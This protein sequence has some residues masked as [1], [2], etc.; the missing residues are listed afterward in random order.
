MENLNK[1]LVE[2]KMV[3]HKS[4]AETRSLQSLNQLQLSIED[5]AAHL[6]LQVNQVIIKPYLN[7]ALDYL[8]NSRD[9]VVSSYNNLSEEIA[10]EVEILLETNRV[11]S[12]KVAEAKHLISE[13]Q[14]LIRNR[15]SDATEFEIA[16]GVLNLD[17]E[18]NT[19]A[20]NYEKQMQLSQEVVKNRMRIQSLLETQQLLDSSLST[21]VAE[22]QVEIDNLTLLLEN[23]S[24]S[25]FSGKNSREGA[26]FAHGEDLSRTIANLS[27]AGAYQDDSSLYAETH[28]SAVGRDLRNLA[29]G[30][31]ADLIE[32]TLSVDQ[33]DLFVVQQTK[34]VN[35]A[36]VGKK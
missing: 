13:T 12:V 35:L 21:R 2:V 30:K 36:R 26:K 3:E 20:Q 29:E 23:L 16:S 31:E 15:Y 22:I 19:V 17:E 28:S 8:L 5:K 27:E 6:S 25:S 9:E 14:A 11:L 10:Q 32:G 7:Q 34:P 24:S 1:E 18:Y 33:N 4:S